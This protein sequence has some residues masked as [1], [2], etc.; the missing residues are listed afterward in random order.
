V[1]YL[2]CGFHVEGVMKDEFTLDGVDVD[3][4]LVA[5]ALQPPPIRSMGSAVVGV[6]LN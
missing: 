1:L 6:E 2:R 3:E 4:H 5:I